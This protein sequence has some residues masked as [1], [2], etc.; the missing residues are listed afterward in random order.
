MRKLPLFSFLCSS[1]GCQNLRAASLDTGE[2][3][4]LSGITTGT[5]V[6]PSAQNGVV[7]RGKIAGRHLTL[8]VGKESLQ[9]LQLTATEGKTKHG[10]TIQ[11]MYAPTMSLIIVMAQR[12]MCLDS[13]TTNHAFPCM[14]AQRTK[15][16]TLIS[17]VCKPIKQN[18]QSLSPKSRDKECMQDAMQPRHT[19]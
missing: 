10:S 17:N 3:H 9:N 8:P 12:G 14:M 5:G 15:Y 11:G 2:C 6:W 16:A 13:R 1:G 18:S 19:S 4:R 7:G